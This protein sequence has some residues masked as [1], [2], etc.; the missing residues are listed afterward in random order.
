M[1]VGIHP[2]SPVASPTT[3]LVEALLEGGCTDTQ[4]TVAASLSQLSWAWYQLIDLWRLGATTV[5]LGSCTSDAS[6]CFV[7]KHCPAV[8]TLSLSFRSALRDPTTAAS[9]SLTDLERE[10]VACR[11]L[12]AFS[13]CTVV[14]QCQALRALNLSTCSRA[15]TDATVITIGAHCQRL[16]SLDLSYC[17]HVSDAALNA[18]GNGCLSLTLL[19]LTGCALLTDAAMTGL[20]SHAPCAPLLEE[21]GLG[22]CER[23]GGGAVLAAAEHCP[24]LRLLDLFG[25]SLVHDA[26][27]IAVVGSCTR[28]QELHLS[29]C[30]SPTLAGR[31][32][33]SS[34][35]VSISVLVVV[36]RCPV[37]RNPS[38]AIHPSQVWRRERR[39]PPCDFHIYHPAAASPAL[40][41]WVRAQPLRASPLPW[42][43]RQIYTRMVCTRSAP[44]QIC[45]RPTLP[46]ALTQQPRL[47][48]PSRSQLR[49]ALE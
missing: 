2:D 14:Q 11:T 3:V 10:L 4:F 7:A 44:R 32:L 5:H 12:E 42:P 43:P 23:V 28:L 39:V 47:T 21:L 17:D 30:A 18:I 16:V 13:V 48:A 25:L 35:Y 15:V 20:L 9:I 36:A 8:E 19:D 24:R 6:L 41:L 46:R 1:L 26:S 40:A 33:P 22:K 29:E 45:A 31:P 37:Q 27:V 49:T 34:C 38:Q